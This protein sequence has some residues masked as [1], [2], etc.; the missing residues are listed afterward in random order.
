MAKSYEQSK[1]KKFLALL[2]SLMMVSTAGAAFASCGSDGSSSSSSG[3]ETEVTETDESVIKNGSFEYNSNDD[4]TLI[5]TSASGWSRSTNSATS[6]SASS[7]Q[8]ASGIVDTSSEAWDNLTKSNLTG[9]LKPEA[10]TVDQAKANWSTMSAYD[11]IKFIDAY[12]D[13]DK[14]ND[15]EDL[16]FY[17]KDTDSFNIDGDDIPSAEV[18][19]GARTG[20]KDGDTNVLMIHNQYTNNRGTAQKYTSSTTVTVK[21]GTSAKVSV[22]VKTAELQYANTGETDIYDVVS[23]RGAYIGITHT[24]GGTTLDQ[25]QVKNIVADEWTEYTFYLQGSSYADS[26]F[27]MVLGLGQGGGT[28]RFEYV[29]GYAFFDDIE[30]TLLTNDEYSVPTGVPAVGITDKASD[31]IFEA[32]ATYKGVT[33]YEIDLGNIVFN[34]KDLDDLSIGITE[35][36]LNG[37]VYVSA[38]G[39]KLTSGDKQKYNQLNFKTAKDIAQVFSSF[40]A[41]GTAASG[42][43]YLTAV[44]NKNFSGADK[45]FSDKKTLMLMSADG[46]AYT[47]NLNE[48]FTVGAGEK[49]A[50]SFFVKT[51]NLEGFTGAGVSLAEI[52]DPTSKEVLSETKLESIDTTSIASVDIGDKED[53]YDGWQQCFFFVDNDTD[54]DKYFTLSFTYGKTTVYGTSK[55][56]YHPGYAAF[57]GFQTLVMSDKEYSCASTGTYAKKV[58]LVGNDST[59]TTTQFDTTATVPTNAIETGFAD[60]AN[61][62]GV[63]GGSGYVSFDGAD[64]T[65]NDYGFA[66]LL[67]EE[68]IDVYKT[69][70]WATSLDLNKL[71]GGA[72]QPLFIYTGETL[73]DDS[74]AMRSYGYIGS[75]QTVSANSYQA[76]SV[77]VKVANGATAAVYLVGDD[78]SKNVL[79]FGRQ[80]TFWYDDDGNVCVEDPS[81]NDKQSNIAFKLQKNGL[82][83]VNSAWKNASG[84]EGYFANLAVYEKDENGN[85]IVA[86]GGVSYDYNDNWK[87]AGNDGIAFYYNE[88]D[89]KYYAYYDESSKKYSTEVQQLP[90]SVARYATEEG[91]NLQYVITGDANEAWQTIVFY[92][93]TG[94]EAFNYRLEVW[95]GTRDG[96]TTNAVGS[97]VLF[98]TNGATLD[99]ETFSTLIEERK[100]LV[101]ETAYF[102]DVYSFYDSAK[103]LR[104][105]ETIDKNDVGNS[106]ESYLSSTYTESV[107]YLIYKETNRYETYLDYSLSDVTVTADVDEDDSS[108]TTTDTN[109]TSDTNIALLVSSLIIAVALVF[110]VVS[111]IL[112]KLVFKNRKRKPVKL[113]KKSKKSDKE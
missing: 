62:K 2:L 36:E 17:D 31:K 49:I 51:S 77:R 63:Y 66:G 59:E 90:E 26:T 42:N 30:C 107:A 68:Y 27:T 95:S 105:D 104:Y 48:T 79:T 3:S 15:A 65:V 102:E 28:D 74:G 89:Q 54:A 45:L 61:Y 109:E 29:N 39:K 35:E 13:A 22:W 76:I 19:P 96:N 38:D 44:Y 12:E 70:A 9:D 14:D 91:K 103:F 97:Y 87:N 8:A 33:S 85:L 55:T 94:S 100:E 98:N 106:Y 64:T 6:G 83:T 101:D 112:R 4:T 23:N 81:E 69:Q 110:A 50:V 5:I 1:H 71:F 52:V 113:E 20:A 82:Y 24:V 72:T 46:A 56:D 16:S 73:K 32:D 57:T 93:K 7:S 43:E 21:A 86:D 34:D 37:V 78:E 40:S 92:V 53:I 10:L 75:K 11:K 84:Y 108:D 60:L 25:F 111:V 80:L 67:N 41:M 47:A 99:E 58:S 88:A 18:N